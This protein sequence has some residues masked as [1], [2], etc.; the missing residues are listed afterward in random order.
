MTNARELL[1]KHPTKI[2]QALY[3]DRW[4]LVVEHLYSLD[5]VG[6]GSTEAGSGLGRDP[7]MT[8][9][10]ASAFSELLRQERKRR[11]WSQADVAEKVG[12]DFNTVSRWERGLNVPSPYF[13]QRLCDI[14]E[15]NP[16]GF[17]LFHEPHPQTSAGADE[18]RESSSATLPV[19]SP[20]GL[21]SHAQA[22]QELAR[23]PLLPREYGVGKTVQP[24][25]PTGTVTLLFTDIEGSTRLL[26]QLGKQYSSVLTQCR[27]LLR[28]VYQTYDGYEVDTHGDAFFVVFARAT[29]A[30]CAAVAIHRDLAAHSWPQ[31]AVVQVRIGLHTG[32]P[33]RSAEGYI[34]LDVHHAARIMGVG[35]GGQILLSQAT[36]VLV[37]QSL[38]DGVQLQDLGEHRLKDLRRPSRLF[39]L[40]VA[41]LPHAFPPLKTLDNHPN[42]LPIEPT[43]FIGRV[44]EVATLCR[45]LSRSEVRLLTLTGPGGVG[46]TRL[47]LQ[48]AAEVSD[49]YADGVFVAPLAPLR[50]PEQVIE[51]IAQVLSIT[52]VSNPSLFGQVQRSLKSK[53]ML[54]VLD[55][56]EH[57]AAAALLVAE[58]LATC[59]SL[60]IV[61]TSR[62]ALHVRAE[63]EFAVPPLSLPDLKRL[64]D[65]VAL[66]QYES[67][68]LFIERAQAVKSDFQVTNATA[69]AVAGIC[70][71]LD[72]L[73]L[74]IELAAARAKY[75]T[76]QM[77]LARLEQGLS[78]LS[79]GA[80]DLPARQQTLRA[81][82]AWSYEL[83]SLQEQQFFRR[84]AVF[85]DGWSWQAAEQVCT[86]A[87]GLVGDILE[88]LESLGDKS[89]LRQEGQED[90]EPRWGML[91]TLREFGLEVLTSAGEAEAIRQAH[92]EYYL[93]LAEEDEPRLRGIGQEHWF[94]HLEQEHENLRAA[95]TWLLEQAHSQ[96][97]TQQG[98]E[99]AERV[100][101]LCAALHDFWHMGDYILE[102]QSFLEQALAVRSSVALSVQAN[103]LSDAAGMAFAIDDMERAETLDDEGLALYR[104]LGDR[105][106]IGN[107]LSLLG[108]VARVRGQYPLAEARL[109]EAAAL[110]RDQGSSLESSINLTEWARV[111]TEQGQ[112]EH[113][114]SLLEESVVLNQALGEKPRV[115]WANYLLA[116]LLFVSQHDPEQAQRLAE[117]SLAHFEEQGIDWMRAF[118][119]GLLGQMH[120][121]RGE[122]AL[123]RVKLEESVVYQQEKGSRADSAEPLQSLARAAVAQHDLVE[124]RRRCQESLRIQVEIGS[125]EV[126]PA[127]LEVMG[128]LV[129][130]QG[131]AL[132]A[133]ELWGT[134]E[135]L[136]EVLGV[137]MYPVE[138]TDYEKGVATAQRKVGEEAFARAWAKG[139]ITPVEQV[140]ATVLKMG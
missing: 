64:P 7:L 56:F 61:I 139:R 36:S 4:D 17:G 137:P 119:L 83:L 124:A 25:L 105:V 116:R 19:S 54:L 99:Q 125:R 76:P 115:D 8:E 1:V 44:Q 43:P 94:A 37:E 14:F 110:F 58:L 46:K 74:A 100:L 120:L 49:G 90:S 98:Q 138:R 60:K 122:W 104:A 68:A 45:L 3:S 39:Q 73:P 35:H 32:E 131:R 106:G 10:S 81:T 34:G 109:E 40:V 114:Q 69:P 107:C 21:S 102:G 53:Q 67:I 50:D 78:V 89:L 15:K 97:E 77:L 33:Q 127:C 118:A 96:V 23:S 22:V 75:Y 133:V 71:R 134:A 132:E 123:A 85:V 24:S 51:A 57:V 128:A 27:S 55:N 11:G 82:I 42:N 62:V 88:G 38:P 113:A 87:S 86:A 80:H 18:Q 59:P 70:V 111:A 135:A 84:L 48:T 9:S 140:I 72:G 65:L 12:T 92:A 20:S 26:Q 6:R 16:E 66:T 52:D 136:R 108:S 28:T 112:Y 31:N 63:R 117:Q 103:V 41:G 130:E 79:G 101:R 121:A 95:L 93:T 13:I 29:D 5:T 47:A 126:M 91:Q 129:A 30:V 2:R